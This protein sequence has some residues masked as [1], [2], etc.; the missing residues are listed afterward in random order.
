MN[1]DSKY[2]I[3]DLLKDYNK[4][5]TE[6]KKKYPDI[7]SYLDTSIESLSALSKISSSTEFEKNQQSSSNK[8]L[9]P[10]L[11]I[12][13]S[14]HNK[15]FLPCLLL[16][17]KLIEYNF[18]QKKNSADITQILKTIFD[19]SQEENQLKIIEIS[20]TLINSQIF[21]VENTPSITN[22]LSIC[23]KAFSYKSIDFK[24]PIR[25]SL[26]LLTTLIFSQKS[27]SEKSTILLTLNIYLELFEG[28][29]KEPFYTSIITKCLALELIVTALSSLS[30]DIFFSNKELKEIV[31]NNLN[32]QIS[33]LINSS[34]NNEMLIGIKTTRIAFMMMNKYH[35]GFEFIDNILKYSLSNVAWMKQIGLEGLCKILANSELIWIIY[36]DHIDLYKKILDALNKISIEFYSSLNK[37]KEEYKNTIF[38]KKK[39]IDR[40]DI[41]IENDDNCAANITYNPR[42]I[43]KMLI[44]CYD[45]LKNGYLT[46]MNKS[47]ILVNQLN[48]NL[49]PEQNEK[50][51]MLN[52]ESELIKSSLTFIIKT[53]NDDIICQSYLSIFQS[54]TGI[55]SSIYL[56]L[57]RDDY[58][59]NLCDLLLN[60]EDLNPKEEP[61]ENNKITANENRNNYLKYWFKP[62][63]LLI[64]QTLLNLS[65]CIN[66]LEVNS[67]VILITTLQTFQ[68]SLLSKGIGTRKEY[69]DAETLLQDTLAFIK[70]FSRDY[71]PIKEKKQKEDEEEKSEH[72][73]NLIRLF[74]SI[75]A[76]FIDSNIFD[77][78]TLC[79]VIFALSQVIK[80]QIE[81]KKNIPIQYCMIKIYQITVIN[82]LRIELI[83]K[84]STQ[85][86]E[87]IFEKNID[88]I[89]SF[90]LDVISSMIISI[91]SKFVVK[92][93]SSPDYI[94]SWGRE[95]FQR[96]TFNP[97]MLIAS[98]SLAPE[99]YSHLLDNMGVIVRHTG[100]YFDTFGWSSFIE[101]CS[102]MINNNSEKT[103][104]LVKLVLSDYN[105]FL[106]P[107]NIIP[108]LSLLG[109]FALYE[110]DS[111]VCYSAIELFWSCANLTENFQKLKTDLIL[112]QKDEPSENSD[113]E[114]SKIVFFNE[115]WKHI[116]FKLTNVNMD[117]RVDVRK[118][119]IKV[120]GDIFISKIENISPENRVFII[121]EIFL[122]MF[123]TNVGK[124]RDCIKAMEGK[125]AEKKWEETATISLLIISRIVHAFIN[126]SNIEL[127]NQSNIYIQF[128]EISSSMISFC[129]PEVNIQILKSL[130]ELQIEESNPPICLLIEKMDYYWK[131]IDEIEK[132]LLSE[133]FVNKYIP[134]IDGLKLLFEIIENFKKIFGNNKY[135]EKYKN[136]LNTSNI[137]HFLKLIPIILTCAQ[138]HDPRNFTSNPHKLMKIEN[139][140]F[141]FL[142]GCC[143]IA[144][145][146]KS[147]TILYNY[148][149]SFLSY[150]YEKPHT[151][152]LCK[153]SLLGLTTIYKNMHFPYEQYLT[154]LI[155][156]IKK[157]LLL[158]SQNEYVENIIKYN[159]NNSPLLFQTI[160]DQ[161]III[162]KIYIGKL[163]NESI[164]N[165]IIN[166]YESV[167][168]QT[169]VGYKSIQRQ[170]QE[171]LMKSSMEMEIQIINFIVNSLIPNSLFLSQEL[172][173]KLLKLLDMGC[174]LDYSSFSNNATAISKICIS[175]LF[176]LCKYKSEKEIKKEYEELV[177]EKTI[178]EL[179]SI[180][181][182]IAKM[183]TPILIKRCRDMMR[184]FLDDEIKSGAMPLSRTRL[185][186]IKFVL[187]KIK[188]LD[189]YP[190]FFDL[191]KKKKN[192]NSAHESEI[193]VMDVV[194]KSKKAHLF[195]LHPILAEFIITKENDIKMIIRDIFKLISSQ[196]GIKDI[197]LYS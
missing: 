196:M 16:L 81:S 95:S 25:L 83:F 173:S 88:K 5:Q 12:S 174:N 79:N 113:N 87:N 36:K 119:G 9:Q 90:S 31:A 118:S 121:N 135:N 129:S 80:N 72:E 132:Y 97:L 162:I 56:P 46:I 15:I 58:L 54:L 186:E 106:T 28:K 183:C 128:L 74:N 157:L 41:F 126:H 4:L 59:T 42:Y 99:I 180:K 193:C 194:S 24:N 143:E 44:E 21:N 185:E 29:K 103:F 32:K 134:T 19:Q 11:Q 166:L 69:L 93:A 67:W 73:E 136:L 163:T 146:D 14:K 127:V 160:S 47:D 18:L 105:P 50:R 147:L 176:T 100:K 114:K 33:K 131:I 184:K 190:D 140:I 1:Y 169:E 117:E 70:Q 51:E 94:S 17:K 98:Q 168:K 148:L 122:K 108:L 192:N 150:D 61:K 188:T 164:W 195:F 40:D 86:L 55:Y 133:I 43:N 76:L 45:N 112:Y 144:T 3:P 75:E 178:E 48:F 115:I 197:S 78:E 8:L 53:T 63:K 91:I 96:T 141:D 26:K 175:N 13:L 23:L 171:E 139:G 110:N 52:Y 124:Y 151:E 57:V 149:F 68:D 30:I 156:T 39:T 10:L 172:Q 116:F 7:Q 64:C 6:T 62:K 49:S 155:S 152:A 191:E 145:D 2:F 71:P 35:I 102:I 111:N 120:F 84:E 101:I 181:I 158:R 167:F 153:R 137:E 34:L 38:S 159:K 125:V 37:E 179:I 161:L 187:D 65:H 104:D 189:V 123:K 22:M 130:N 27:I 60:N 89:S 154:D 92:P 66:L 77:K 165:S 182:K 107:Y 82:V 109:T 142:D 85:I 20:L 170:Y 138:Q 177:E